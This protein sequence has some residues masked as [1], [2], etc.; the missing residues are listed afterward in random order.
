MNDA[1]LRIAFFGMEALLSAACL[2]ALAAEHDVVA[3]VR[4]RM[5]P[6]GGTARRVGGLLARRLGLRPSDT[7]TTAARANRVPQWTVP[8]SSMGDARFSERLRRLRLDLVCVAH[9]PWRLPE[10]VLGAARLGGVNVHASLLPRHRGPLPLFWVYYGD[11]R[12]TG[13]T[14]HHMADRFDSGDIIVQRAFPLARGFPV[15]ELNATNARVG[16]EVLPAAIRALARGD[17]SRR[18][19]EDERATLA[20]RVRPGD[21]MVDFGA[22]DVERVWHFLAGLWPRFI[23]PLTDDGGRAASYKSVLGYE[24]RPRQAPTGCVRQLD[25]ERFALQCRDGVVLLRR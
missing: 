7:L 10:T 4:A 22:W 18:P 16:G 2:Q 17:S 23:E 13:V 8:A 6:R 5:T 3:V 1:R 20:P 14:V 24:R 11:D 9:F 12:E 25:V 15:D 19:Q 21:R